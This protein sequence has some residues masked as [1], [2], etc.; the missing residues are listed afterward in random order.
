MWCVLVRIVSGSTPTTFACQLSL[1]RLPVPSVDATLKK[2]LESVTPLFSKEEN[3]RLKK[4]A[5][6]CLNQSVSVS[7]VCVRSTKT[8]F[9][10][11]FELKWFFKNILLKEYSVILTTSFMSWIIWYKQKNLISKISVDSNFT[12]SSYAWICVFHCSHRLLCWIKSC[13][14]DFL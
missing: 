9:L 2:F 12:F 13:E 8:S 5:E 1:P 4:E 7:D 14:W 10:S 6:V 11:I 3:E